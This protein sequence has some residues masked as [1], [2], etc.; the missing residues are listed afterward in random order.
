M[1][2]EG[3]HKAYKINDRVY[4]CGTDI[5][6]S[7]IGGKWKCVVLWYLRHGTL[8]FS[9]L[10]R[11]I[12]DITEKMLSIQ[13]KSLQE[14]GLI[15][16]LSFGKRAPFRVQYELTDF[17]LSLIPVIEVITNWGIELGNNKGEIIEVL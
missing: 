6:M 7:Y 16:R 5:T 4:H 3:K 12:P 2:L 17:G 1:I 11:L 13:L 10:K 8:R 9:E 14:D 15:T